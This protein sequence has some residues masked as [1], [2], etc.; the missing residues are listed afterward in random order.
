MKPGVHQ[1]SGFRAKQIGKL[2]W[3]CTLLQLY[4]VHHESFA[5]LKNTWKTTRLQ[6]GQGSVMVP[7]CLEM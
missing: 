5:Y 3:H 4:T 7:E 6:V 2:V 1:Q